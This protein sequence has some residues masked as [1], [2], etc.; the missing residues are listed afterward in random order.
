MV[1]L[2]PLYSYMQDDSYR[3]RNCR[4]CGS[5][6]DLYECKYYHENGELL[7]VVLCEKHVNEAEERGVEFTRKE[8]IT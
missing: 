8:S 1:R 5:D 3:L 4:Q 7:T 6:E 2:P